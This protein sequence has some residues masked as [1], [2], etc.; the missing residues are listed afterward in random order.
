MAGETSTRTIDP[1]PPD[2]VPPSL[3]TCP[4]QSPLI[5][6]P[7]WKLS[8]RRHCAFTRQS[9]ASSPESLPLR[10]VHSLDTI[11]S[12][13]TSESTHRPTRSTEIQTSS[14]TQR[15]GSRPAGSKKTRPPNSRKNAA[16]SGLSA[17]EAGCALVVIS[18]CK[19]CF[20]KSRRLNSCLLS[21]RIQTRRGRGIY[22]LP[23]NDS[24]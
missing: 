4:R 14:P 9:Q 5:T 17:A 8:S 22:Q 3:Q 19:V 11:T 2:Q 24:Q 7:F 6:C 12:L 20:I 21:S 13:P 15:A 1:R 23:H 10:L 18:H 16:G